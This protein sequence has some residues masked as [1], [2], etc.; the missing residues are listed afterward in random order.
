MGLCTA[1]LMMLAGCGEGPFD[2]GRAQVAFTAHLVRLDGEQV[3]LTY[4]QF[5]CGVKAE[6]WTVEPLGEERSIGRLSEQA[7]ALQ[8]ADDVRIEPQRQPYV[9]VR[10]EFK[11][12]APKVISIQDEDGETKIIEAK[13]GPVLNHACFGE[14]NPPFLMGIHKGDFQQDVAPRF[15]FKL[16]GD[17]A[18][19][20]VLH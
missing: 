4:D 3:A 17:W 15:E 8:F 13:A 7:R 20:R 16:N 10:G 14:S 19:E 6:L 2:A 11:L 18:V 5:N 9:Q 12:V 1:G